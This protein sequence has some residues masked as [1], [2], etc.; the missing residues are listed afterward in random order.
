MTNITI[1][2]GVNYLFAPPQ[3]RQFRLPESASERPLPVKKIR[4]VP[5]VSAN[6]DS[7]LFRNS[8]YLRGATCL[9][10]LRKLPLDR[11]P[12]Y[13]SA[14]KRTPE[15][16]NKTTLTKNHTIMVARHHLGRRDSKRLLRQKRLHYRGTCHDNY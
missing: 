10:L 16:G 14:T 6:F 15:G 8:N 12:Y 1:Q 9:I 7:F 3:E 11:I 5:K 13:R 2:F 4:T